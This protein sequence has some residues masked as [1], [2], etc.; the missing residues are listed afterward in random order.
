MILSDLCIRR[1][2]FA[3]MLIGALVVVGLFC[4]QR[5]GVDL[6]PRVDIPT[7]TVTTTLIGAGPEEIETR[8][9]KPIEEAINTISGID[10]LR[11]V[12]VE[13]LSQVLVL[14]RLE[15]PLDVAAQ[16][17]RDKVAAIVAQL[18]E[19]TD[20]PIVDKFDIDATPVMYLTV[21]GSRDLKALTELA[22][23]QIKEP[24][25]SLLGVGA[26]RLIG[27]REREVQVAVQ[28]DKLSGYGLT[29]PEIAR[30][31]T[32]QNVEIPGGRLTT[33][34]QETAVR[35]L[36]RVDHVED[37]GAVQV[38]NRDG[39]PVRIRDLATVSDGIVEP[40]SLSRYNGTNAVTLAIR[41]QSGANTVAVVD[42][43]RAKLP[44]IRGTL[45]A[46]VQVDIT[47]DWSTFIRNAVDEVQ[48]HMVLGAILASVVVLLFMGNFRATIIAA[49]AIP[50]SVIATF[51][52][53]Y[54][55]DFS[56]NRITLLALTLAIGIVIDDAIVVLE[57]IWRFIEEK[58]LDAFQAAREATAEVGLA[59][60]ATTLSLVAV[61][62]PVAFVPGVVG[63]FLK[64]FGLTMAFAI[65]VSLLVAFTLT[66]TLSARLLRARPSGHH[67]RDS[68]FYAPIDRAYMWLL[69]W[70]MRHR[71]IVVFLALLLIASTPTLARLAG[72]AFMPEDDRAEFEVNLKLPQGSSLQQVDT[73]LRNMEDALHPIPEIRGLL[74]TVGGTAGDDITTA[75]ILV[76]LSDQHERSR[77]QHLIMQDARA[78]LQAFRSRVRVTVDNPPP[79]S[80]SGFGGSELRIDIR[81]AEQA[82][83]ERAAAKLRQI[84]EATPGV[85]DIDSTIVA[86]KPEVQLVIQRDRAADLGVQVADIARTVR[87]LVAGDVVT[88]Y[89]EAGELYD[90]R[91]RLTAPDR[92]RAAQ[93]GELMI[94][95]SKVGRVRLDNLV[96]LRTGTGPAQINRNSRQ[97]QISLN[98]N[99]APGHAFGDILNAILARAGNLGLPAT[100]TVGVSGRGKLYAQTVIG[101]Q[102]ALGLSVIFMYMVLAAQFESLLHPLTIM[103]SLPLS[104]PF[105]IFSLWVTGNTINL[106]SGLGIL[107]LFG[108]VKKNSILQI[109]HTLTLRRAGLPELDA[110]MQANRDR[111][112]AILMTTI[113]LVAAMIPAAFA[114][115]SGAETTRSIAIV[116]IGGQTLCL[117]ITLLITPVAYSLFEDLGLRVGRIFA[118]VRSLSVPRGATHSKPEPV[119][120]KPTP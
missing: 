13:G 11:S 44:A 83:L 74:T 111:L 2:V 88:Q 89:K 57:N 17:V 55:A 30:A 50:T 120:G 61:F 39:K 84:M 5:L 23:K 16:D 24:L 26:I 97:R 40:R 41:K 37:F 75:Q 81:G 109:D 80:G 86:G 46:G 20:P 38:A 107:L 56:L 101:F 32:Y 106:F 31:L 94:P 42:A 71:F 18:P 14:F 45:P 28:A 21:S 69:G 118:A 93:L 66:P 104:V 72:G 105:A 113:A 9:T 76:V 77:H 96:D 100:Y 60:S 53:M 102:I 22:K 35:T 25:E 91:L 90:V 112:R 54:A 58:Q 10:E 7:V 92:A 36:G 95:S 103:L 73:L 64:S 79:V 8:I 117:L 51:A 52:V 110:I 116:V 4:Y 82:Q 62:V 27:G 34:P 108:I 33:G 87:T 65:I 3:S 6:F 49:L 1:P 29:V 63:Q 98:A 68:W 70:S 119:A 78:R 12:S 43:I 67:S 15:R 59:V 19:G 99:I 48:M 114:R 47:R 85:V 115:G